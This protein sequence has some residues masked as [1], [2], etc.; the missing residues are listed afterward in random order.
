MRGPSTANRVSDRRSRSAT[1]II[2]GLDPQRCDWHSGR[3]P[4][5]V[6]AWCA[7]PTSGGQAESVAEPLDRS[8]GCV[9]RGPQQIPSEVGGRRC[10]V[11]SGP[12]PGGW[13]VSR[14]R[15]TRVGTV[16]DP[17]RRRPSM[18]RWAALGEPRIVPDVP[19]HPS[20]SSRATRCRSRASANIVPLARQGRPLGEP[21]ESTRRRRRRVLSSVGGAP[22]PHGVDDQRHVLR[23][24]R[25][26][27]P[28]Q[29][30]STISTANTVGLLDSVRAS[31]SDASLR[32][33]KH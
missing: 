4:D 25:P 26:P 27:P 22:A 16:R 21:S 28:R 19:A 3:R 14:G 32:P 30:S 1:P 6:M 31:A 13:T 15:S 8:N 20:S 5:A 23:G 18:R 7:T 29:S 10:V 9:P 33:R 11:G 2:C 24:Q 12:A 17:T